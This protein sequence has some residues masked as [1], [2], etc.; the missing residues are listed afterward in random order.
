MWKDCRFFLYFLSCLSYRRSHIYLFLFKTRI[1]PY[2][3]SD[4]DTL[5]IGIPD[6]SVFYL[7]YLINYRYVGRYIS[8][9]WIRP[10]QPNKVQAAGTWLADPSPSRSSLAPPPARTRGS[11]RQRG[12]AAQRPL[13]TSLRG[14]QRPYR[15]GVE[16]FFLLHRRDSAWI[17]RPLGSGEAA[18]ASGD[19]G[20]LW[21]SEGW[22]WGG[23][24]SCRS[25]W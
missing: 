18:T 6:V 11:R 21:A 15:R 17:R 10:N 5:P 25:S 7:I 20:D 19:C 13:A 16:F 1:L 23:S 24:G 3:V 9:G 14:S 8:T 22:R 2:P 12:V 4:T